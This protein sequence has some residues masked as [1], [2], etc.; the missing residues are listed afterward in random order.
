MV[1]VQS[2][3]NFKNTN[4]SMSPLTVRRG[5]VH[6]HL[7]SHGFACAVEVIYERD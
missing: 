7:S 2:N 4:E 3:I 1:S 6:Y 5:G